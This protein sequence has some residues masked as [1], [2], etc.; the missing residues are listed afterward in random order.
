MGVVA[1]NTRRVMKAKCI[2]QSLLAEKAGFNV[3]EFNA[4]LTGRKVMREEHILSI[5]KALDVLPAD[6]FAD[7]A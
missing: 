7:T 4:L 2:K 5:A 3:K 6:L 1:T